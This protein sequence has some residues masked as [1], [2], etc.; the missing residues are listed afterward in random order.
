MSNGKS[1]SSL[2]FDEHFHHHEHSPEVS[3]SHAREHKLVEVHLIGFKVALN[4]SNKG[5]FKEY[6]KQ[7]NHGAIKGSPS[8]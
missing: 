1:A 3:G 4:D 2:F 8:E 7:S 5:Q 6:K